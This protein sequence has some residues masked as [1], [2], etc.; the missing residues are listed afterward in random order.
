MMLVMSSSDISGDPPNDAT[1]DPY[2]HDQRRSELEAALTARMLKDDYRDIPGRPV[3]D[4]VD[5]PPG[6]LDG[7]TP[8]AS[9]DRSADQA[10]DASGDAPGDHSA[11]AGE[12][13]DSSS[14]Q[15]SGAG[16][17]ARVL[18]RLAE[19]D[20][21]ASDLRAELSEMAN[22][23]PDVEEQR[24]QAEEIRQEVRD[25]RETVIALAG[26]GAGQD[27][28]MASAAAAQAAAVASDTKYARRRFRD[29][30]AWKRLWQA[31]KQVAPH[32]WALIS[33]LVRV[34]EWS[35]TGQLGTG[36]L[37]LASAGISVTFG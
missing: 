17:V 22:R 27:P 26:R 30:P 1:P 14:G 6:L 12:G 16:E 5:V 34:K 32:L 13:D 9:P 24:A 11:A 20:R 8:D 7:E 10:V 33:R 23:L 18:D 37:G 2:G 31:V 25:L 35:V 28:S 3:E 15:E 36:V 21:I 29:N 19:V 4:Q